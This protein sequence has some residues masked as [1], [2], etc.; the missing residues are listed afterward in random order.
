MPRKRNLLSGLKFEIS[1]SER[2]C[3]ASKRHKIQPG[4]EHLALYDGL[5]RRNFFLVCSQE[6][7]KNTRENIELIESELSKK[8]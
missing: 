7:L 4:E 8:L 2:K 1:K 5:V 6:I 3:H